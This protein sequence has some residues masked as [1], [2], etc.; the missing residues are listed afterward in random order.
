MRRAFTVRPTSV[1]GAS[2][3]ALLRLQPL[4]NQLYDRVGRDHGFLRAALGESASRC[5]W[6]ARQL[7]V[8]ARVVERASSKPQLLLPNSVYLQRDELGVAGAPHWVH[9]VGNVQAGE[10][11]Q[12]QLVHALHSEEHEGVQGGPLHAVC[13]AL[14]R[15]ARL[16]HPHHPC[17]AVL[18][19]PVERLALRTRADVRGVGARLKREHGVAT[20]LYVSM[21]E[22]AS[23]TVDEMTGDLRLAPGS[24]G[25]GSSSSRGGAAPPISVVYSR[26]DF[27][28]PFGAFQPHHHHHEAARDDGGGAWGEWPLVEALERSNAVISSPLGSRMAHRRKVLHAL[29][30]RGEG[31]GGE[32]GGGG[33]GGGLERFLGAADAAALR[34]VLPEQWHLG[35]ADERAEAEALV[36]ADADGFVAKNMLRPR[37]GSGATQDRAA[38]GG[39][40]VSGG[41]ALRSLLRDKQR[42]QWYLLSRRV[43]PLRTHDAEVVNAAHDGATLALT[44]ARGAVASSE[45][46]TF[47]VFLSERGGAPPLLNC[48]AG[49][50]ARVRP[51]DLRH[52][53]AAEVGYG[54]LSCVQSVPSA[55]VAQRLRVSAEGD[56]DQSRATPS[57]A[58]EL[59][60]HGRQVHRQR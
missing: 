3:D 30:R 21:A 23:A 55:P 35:D 60:S 39:A 28:H 46:A 58:V 52:P 54:A 17:V 2:V 40:L 34:A 14:A 11:Y 19:K 37:T 51:A 45:V 36:A 56:F 53:L 13:E 18:S 5:A 8:H 50:G 12:L 20:V 32:G 27:S 59:S 38:S 24:M 48:A 9:T 15:A 57:Q 25:M 1:P 29:T 49:I 47:G 43:A 6:E 44:A 31:G 33:G 42:R 26:Y 4:W 22:L 10:P 16:V 7:A 41:A